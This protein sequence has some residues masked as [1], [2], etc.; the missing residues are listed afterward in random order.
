M[1]YLNFDMTLPESG[2]YS[3]N[4][5]PVYTDIHYSNLRYDPF[6]LD[7]QKAALNFTHMAVD[8]KAVVYAELPAIKHWR[9]AFDYWFKW[10]VLF[11]SSL[12]F[13]FKK[14]SAIVT[15]ELKATHDGHLYPHLHDLRINIEKS[16]LYHKQP[17]KQFMYR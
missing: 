15:T 4:S 6:Q 1:A 14:M 8:N 7:L 5:F 10:F 16:K 11:D 2:V 9:V 3:I 12:E 13:D 17:L